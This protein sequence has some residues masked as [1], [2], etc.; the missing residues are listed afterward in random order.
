MQYVGVSIVFRSS[1]SLAEK[2]STEE[3]SDC[4]LAAITFVLKLSSHLRVRHRS[5]FVL[6]SVVVVHAVS[7]RAIYMDRAFSP[8]I[9]SQ[10]SFSDH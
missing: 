3:S 4:L 5:L 6:G 8:Q 7:I 1:I 10:R 9:S 2:P